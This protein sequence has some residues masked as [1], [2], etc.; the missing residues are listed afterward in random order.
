MLTHALVA[1]AAVIG[2]P[3]STPAPLRGYPV[4]ARLAEGKCT[5][6]IQ[7]MIMTNQRDALEWMRSL[8]DKSRQVDIVI[9]Q[10]SSDRCVKSAKSLTRKAGF[11]NIVV[12]R[13]SGSEYSGG[14]PPR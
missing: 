6:L 8:P 3:Q 14:L 5:Y 1:V 12:R 2:A 4:F 11:T 9:D 13:G 10:P 7:D